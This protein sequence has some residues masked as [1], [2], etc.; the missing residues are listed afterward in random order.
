MYVFVPP[1]FADTC[2]EL[3]VVLRAHHTNSTHAIDNELVG[4]TSELANLT[5]WILGKSI[6]A[7]TSSSFWVFIDS[8]IVTV[9]AEIY[10]LIR[11]AFWTTNSSLIYFSVFTI[12][13]ISFPYFS[14]WTFHAV[15]WDKIGIDS[16]AVDAFVRLRQ[17]ESC[18]THTCAAL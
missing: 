6:I 16:C 1:I 15:P 4:W 5:G 3:A 13:A 8:T 11:F 7:H 14:N 12:T 17:S 10:Q 9:S 18:L 2:F